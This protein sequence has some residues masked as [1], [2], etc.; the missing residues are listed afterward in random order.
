MS[1]RNRRNRIVLDEDETE[2]GPSRP[3][4]RTALGNEGAG[5]VQKRR[6]RDEE[7]SEA[8]SNEGSV[9]QHSTIAEKA[10]QKL[11]TEEL[12]RKVKDVV[13]LALFS[14]HRK[15]P[16]KRDDIVKKV[17]HEH[18]R[19]FQVVFD[20]AQER[21]E[22]IFGMSLAELPKKSFSTGG[23]R[24]PVGNKDKTTKSYVLKNILPQEYRETDIISWEKNNEDIMGLLTIVLSLIHVNGRVL[25]DDQMTHYFRRLYLVNNDK[26]D[27]EKLLSTFVKQGYLDKQKT[28]RTDQSQNSE[29]EPL[30]YRWGPRAKIEM[31]ESNL[32]KFIRAIFGQDAPPDLD[33]QVERS[34]G[35][36][37]T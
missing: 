19:A 8:S 30:E 17:L 1:S 27:L 22:D 15:Q 21:L 16:I 26:F 37:L 25:S 33:K 35:I 23:I 36:D 18:S 13:R 9:N 28:S 14:E 31:P 11:T 32:I 2:A 12:E 7:E 34:S 20:K 4:R 5:N 24:K 29:K 10:A 3:T 6:R